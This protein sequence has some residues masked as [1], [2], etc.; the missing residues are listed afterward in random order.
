MCRPMPFVAD[1]EL[2]NE[3]EERFASDCESL[4]KLP[5]CKDMGTMY[6][7]TQ[8][9][10]DL[11]L[12]LGDTEQLLFEVLIEDLRHPAF[13]DELIWE[14]MR[15]LGI[16]ADDFGYILENCDNITYYKWQ[17]AQKEKELE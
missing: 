2:E 13:N 11:R 7:L 17:E 9:S 8:R 10:V 12:R 6:E 15:F 14:I 1:K 5:R 4:K 16:R 3:L